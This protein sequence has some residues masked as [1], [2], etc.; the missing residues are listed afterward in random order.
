MTTRCW[1]YLGL[2]VLYLLHN[3]FW[4]WD[5]ADLLLGLP[6]ALLYHIA[7]CF[8]AAGLM[9]LLVNYAWPSK[10]DAEENRSS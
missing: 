8:A 2:F 3:D 7:Y 10:L 9:G 4:L 5:D 6:V 1:L